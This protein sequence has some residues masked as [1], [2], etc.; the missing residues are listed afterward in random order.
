MDKLKLVQGMLT[1]SGDGNSRLKKLPPQ[2]RQLGTT[3]AHTERMTEMTTTKAFEG[4]MRKHRTPR[5]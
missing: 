3:A 5:K 1:Y 4:E 2:G